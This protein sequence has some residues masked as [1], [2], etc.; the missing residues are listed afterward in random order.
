MNV[1]PTTDSRLEGETDQPYA[2][3]HRGSETKVSAQP[4][5][6]AD[7]SAVEVPLSEEEVKV[8]KRTVGAGVPQT[9]G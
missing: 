7:E 1:L 4:R 8:G 5:E 9:C 3:E 6:T 2:D